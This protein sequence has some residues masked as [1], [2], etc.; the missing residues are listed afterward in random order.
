[1]TNTITSDDITRQITEAVNAGDPT[2][3]DIP[4]AVRHFIDTF[5]L[6]DI[7]TIDE[8]KFWGI[9]AAHDSTQQGVDY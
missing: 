5:S 8:S 1:M 2:G 7:D 3:I 6:V 4:A 9:I